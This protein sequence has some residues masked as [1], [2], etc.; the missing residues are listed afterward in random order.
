[1]IVCYIINQ[2][3]KSGPVDVLYNIVKNLDRSFFTPVI[4]KLMEDDVDRS[5]TYKFEELGVE[6][7][8]FSYSFWDLEL[9]TAKVAKT[10]QVFLEKRAVDIIHVHGYHPVLVAAHIKMKCPKIET[11]H[12]ICR[13]DFVSSKG[14]I[15]GRYM[16][17]RYLRNLKEL[18]A[19]VAISD[20]GKNFYLKCL[21]KIPVY[22]IYNG[23]DTLKFNIDRKSIDE[24]SVWRD[25]L[26]LPH[27]KKIFVVVGAIREVKDPLTIIRAFLKLPEQIKEGAL[28]LFLG[29]GNLLETCKSTAQSCPSI[30]FNGYTFNVDEYLKAADYA[31]CASRS[32]GF[33]LA[34]VEALMSG[35][36]VIAS[37]IGPFQEFTQ[38][39]PELQF[40]HFP[41][42]ND[43]ILRE[44]I[45]YAFNHIIDMEDIALNIRQRFSID[46]M[47]KEYM[48]LYKK[49]NGITDRP[50]AKKL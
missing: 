1:M 29:Q 9:R 46:R 12:C 27:N 24:K 39:I 25:K 4:V 26:F 11:M 47:A 40:L 21:K 17:W 48:D 20:T 5:V 2:L 3:R 37:D 28:L 38:G 7:I 19:G 35:V 8:K 22:R 6:I 23:V 14:K 16:I 42:G 10:V 30:L 49:L 50:K 31:I 36:P 41:V 13:E 15:L 33:G 45:E 34:C 44:K 43:A 18:S 32:E